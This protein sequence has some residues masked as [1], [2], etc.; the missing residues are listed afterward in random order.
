MESKLLR[1]HYYSVFK[2][3]LIAQVVGFLL[4]K[5]ATPQMAKVVQILKLQK[6]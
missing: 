2:D 3:W 6:V 4:T 5:E 1:D